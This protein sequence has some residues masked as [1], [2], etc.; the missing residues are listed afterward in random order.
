MSFD[1]SR[2]TNDALAVRPLRS[3]TGRL[4]RRVVGPAQR[5]RRRA[6]VREKD[7]KRAETER[8]GRG[9]EGLRHSESHPVRAV[10]QVRR[11]NRGRR[12]RRER[13][14]PA[15][16]PSAALGGDQQQDGADQVFHFQR[17]GRRS[18]R[19]RPAGHAAAL[20][21]QTGP[22]VRRGAV[23]EPRG[24]PVFLRR[25]RPR[26]S[27][28]RRALRLHRDRSVSDRQRRGREP[29]G[30]ERDDRPHVELV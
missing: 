14:G 3:H 5:G 4:R 15:R 9:R 6:R 13:A 2:R 27:A 21:H 18:R 10:E 24:R 1:R 19:R 7:A 30:Q 20:G 29:A 12:A 17:G 11:D 16:H 23:D 8:F 26:V 28:H 25:R 22:S